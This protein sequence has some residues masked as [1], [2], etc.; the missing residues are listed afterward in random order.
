MAREMLVNVSESEECRIAVVE[1]GVL[2]ELYMERSSLARLGGNIYKGKVVNVEPG[3]QAAFIDFG[4][5][6]NGFLH[7]S[8]LHPKYFSSRKQE[9]SE[10]IGRRKALRERPPIQDCLR[11]GT[12][13]VVQVIKEGVRTKGPTLSTYV[14]L[15]GKYLVMMPWMS[16]MGISQKIED[17]EVRAQMKQVADQIE[18]PKGFGFIMRTAA[19]G[20]SKK[21]IQEDLNYL[22]RLWHA[23]EKRMNGVP[24]PCELYQ[25][26]D[27]VIRTLRDIFSSSI[28]RILCDSEV[29]CQRV[30]DF[31]AIAGRRFGNRVQ[32]YEGK[33]PL[34]H[35]YKIEQEIDKI[36]SKR[37]ELKSGGF[38]V[39]ESTE[40]LV[41]IDVNSG[42]YREEKNAEETAFNINCEAAKE[43]A[44]QLRLRDLGGLI[45]CD[46]IDMRHDKHRREV[47][48][49]FRTEMK[50]D[51][52]RSKIVKISPFG[53]IEMTRQRMR[54]SLQSST[55]LECPYCHGTG[56]VKTQESVALEAIRMLNL[57]AAQ[58][59]VKRIE[60]VVAPNV[61]A[62]L[63]NE[64][65]TAIAHIEQKSDKHITIK[66]GEVQQGHGVHM[67]CY[68]ERGMVVKI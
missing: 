41:A 59:S 45:V 47:E 9:S 42:R 43:I 12:E 64:K 30:S 57:A 19:Q 53:I 32:Y 17:D 58:E 54:P 49:I 4:I 50:N 56:F 26:S 2:E 46:F 66:A 25:E 51:R 62:H 39:I 63:Q 15:P 8:D 16:K 23:I 61:E 31:L 27:L 65:R 13:I 40:A 28:T 10:H 24:A 5:G 22:V 33:T 29:V 37:V 3:I 36:Q 60:L 38:I 34:F 20:C 35:Q 7:V 68:D 44:R 18:L 1:A 6:K 21:V 52:A 11:R 67:I 14:S 48:R 55:Y